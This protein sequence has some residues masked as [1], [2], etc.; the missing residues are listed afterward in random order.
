MIQQGISRRLYTNVNWSASDYLTWSEF[1][2]PKVGTVNS[3]Q[4][5]KQC[6][7]PGDSSSF[8]KFRNFKFDEAFFNSLFA[9][10]RASTL[11]Q[12]TA[13][14]LSVNIHKIIITLINHSKWQLNGVHLQVFNAFRKRR[15]EASENNYGIF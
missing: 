8:T 15:S 2:F 1:M 7:M 10:M 12:G 13:S 4:D 9:T 3:Q 11:Q 5:Q 6:L 14:T